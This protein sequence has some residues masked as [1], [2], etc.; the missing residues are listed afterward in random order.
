VGQ[1]VVQVDDDVD[2][3]SS[4]VQR[5]RGRPKKENSTVVVSKVRSEDDE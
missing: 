4:S 2:S 1:T 3:N 5:G